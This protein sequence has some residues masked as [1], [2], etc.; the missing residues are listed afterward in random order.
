MTN[1]RKKLLITGWICTSGSV[2]EHHLA[3]VGAAGSSPV[4]C[5]QRQT[6]TLEPSGF[7]FF[8]VKASEDD[9]GKSGKGPEPPSFMSRRPIQVSL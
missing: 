3:K 6:E 1:N 8:T 4:S 2:V 5:L 7:L 9:G